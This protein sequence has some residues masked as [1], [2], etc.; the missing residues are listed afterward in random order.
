VLQPP[1]FLDCSLG[2]CRFASSPKN[3]G[4]FEQH[5]GVGLRDRLP[6]RVDTALQPRR[7][8]NQPVL[9]R[10]VEEKYLPKWLASMPAEAMPSTPDHSR[11]SLC[12]FVDTD[13]RV[14]PTA[15]SAAESFNH[16]NTPSGRGV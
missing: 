9:Q 8:R 4:Y 13:L 15:N 12:V 7:P 16:N 10:V 2:L 5:V 14:Q 1:G 6:G 3:G 11:A